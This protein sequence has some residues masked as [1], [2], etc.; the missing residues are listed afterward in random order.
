MG[1]CVYMCVCV[2]EGITIII[3]EVTNLRWPWGHE[4]SWRRK[5]SGGYV[6]IVVPMFFL[7]NINAEKVA[8]FSFYNSIL[9]CPMV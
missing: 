5:G 2:K 7:K 8:Y 3:K 9:M 6:K 4:K 1:M